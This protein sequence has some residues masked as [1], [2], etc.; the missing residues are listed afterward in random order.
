MPADY[1]RPFFTRQTNGQLYAENIALEKLAQQYGTP[2]YVYSLAALKA[3][4][5]AWNNAVSQRD[6]VCYAVKSQ[7]QSC[8]IKCVGSVG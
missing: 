7:F 3:N 6:L 4:F 8:D 1:S 2:L 5:M